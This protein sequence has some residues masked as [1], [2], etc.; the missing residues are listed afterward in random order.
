MKLRVEE[1]KAVTVGAIRIADEADGLHF[2]KC[3]EKQTAVWMAQRADLGQRS[4]TTTGVRLDFHTDSRRVAFT[5]PAGGRFEV[6]VDG[7]LRA[8]FAGKRD[9]DQPMVVELCD[10]LGEAAPG[11]HRVTIVF[12]SHDVGVLSSVELDDGASL[13]RHAFACRMLFIGDSIT[14]GWNSYYDTASY[15]WR[16]SQFFDADSIIQGIGGAYYLA[17]SFDRLSFDPDMVVVAYGTNDFGHYPTLDAMRGQVSGFLDQ[18]A[19]AYAGKGKKIFVLSPIWRGKRE[20]KKMGS[21]A[22]CRALV[23][24]EAER[25]G[26]I[27]IDGLTLVP[28]RPDLFADGY[29]HPNEAGFGYYAQNLIAQMQRY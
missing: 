22:D 28:P 9:K 27:H 7:L 13:R 17:D 11:E 24:E 5:A 29:L 3:T 19:D 6:L 8:V 21:F 4:L 18:L 25:R 16:V 1:I 20:G 14:Q 15:A 23:A 2:Y 26:M 10:P 12:P